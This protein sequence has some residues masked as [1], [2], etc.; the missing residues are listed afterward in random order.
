MRD[1]DTVF[2]S[3]LLSLW[4]KRVSL[5][6][7]AEVI[8]ILLPLAQLFSTRVWNHIQLLLV[9]SIL[10]TGKRT[11][12]SILEVMGLAEQPNFQN[13]HR[14]LNRA[15]WSN[16]QASKI[17]LTSLVMTFIPRGTIVGGIDDTKERRKGTGG[18][19]CAGNPRRR[20]LKK[21]K[22]KGVASRSSK[23]ES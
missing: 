16:L 11:V 4:N 20:A 19:D 7:P 18:I 21:I 14:V 10:T 2:L 23:I 17:L 8:K 3:P 5:N 1:S 22:A 13:Y 9:G 15:V 12:S 6:L